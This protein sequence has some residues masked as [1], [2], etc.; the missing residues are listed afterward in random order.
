MYR[1]LLAYAISFGLLIPVHGQI[2][3]DEPSLEVLLR[4][5]HSYGPFIHSTSGG[6]EFR[7][8]VNTSYFTRW[9]YEAGLLELKTPRE[10]RIAHYRNSRSYIYGKLNN[11]YALRAGGG[12][13]NLLYRKP[14]W[15]GVEVRYFWFAGGSVG[16]TK[17][18]YLYIIKDFILSPNY[19]EIVLVAERYN[20]EEHFL[21]DIFGRAPFFKGLDEIGVHPGAYAKAGFSFDF[22]RQ[23]QRVSA[24]EVGA[25][26]DF[27]PT[28]IPIMALREPERYFLTFFIG[29]YI[30]KRYN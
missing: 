30:G 11:F 19:Y 10:T 25:A 16:F 23:N 22:S 12:Q 1:V 28:G 27:F 2:E 20:P 3:P 26:L 24:I 15:G 9:L 5:E 21:E 14:Y 6:A 7:K 13:Q 18:V 17:P 8:G 29:Y 4:K